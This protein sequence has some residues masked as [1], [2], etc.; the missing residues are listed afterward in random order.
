MSL[1]VRLIELLLET[2]EQKSRTET[3]LVNGL[4]D[5]LEPYVGETP[6]VPKTLDLEESE[7]DFINKAIDKMM[8]QGGIKGKGWY[9]LISA[10]EGAKEGKKSGKV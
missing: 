1:F 10:L 6:K 7:V 5:K 2:V 3:Y 4:S 9:Y 8:S